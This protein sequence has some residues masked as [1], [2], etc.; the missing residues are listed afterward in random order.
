MSQKVQ[1]LINFLHYFKTIFSG[2]FDDA[3]FENFFF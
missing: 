2:E 3:E 1:I